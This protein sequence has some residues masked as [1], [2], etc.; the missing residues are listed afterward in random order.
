MFGVGDVVR[1]R[2]EWVKSS[3]LNWSRQLYRVVRVIRGRCR[4]TYRH[5]RYK[6]VANDTDEPVAGLHQNDQLQRYV[7]VIRGVDS[8][9]RFIVQ[10]LV[11][12]VLRVR[13][14]RRMEMYEVRWKGYTQTTEEPRDTL[15]LDVPH[16]VKRF[17]AKHNVVWYPDKLPTWT[18]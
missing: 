13:Q 7:P 2:V 16:L 4:S 9:E 10:R 12:P 1:L 3:G 6:I 11:T 8:A 15:L 18:K 17:E 5:A 14:G